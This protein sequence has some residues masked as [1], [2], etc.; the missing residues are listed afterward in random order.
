MHFWVFFLKKD[1][2]Q[3][4]TRK[5]H[6]FNKIFSDKWPSF[7][8]W[9]HPASKN[10]FWKGSESKLNLFRT[11]LNLRTSLLSKHLFLCKSHGMNFF[12][13]CTRTN[14]YPV[15]VFSLW[16]HKLLTRILSFIEW[17]VVIT[18]RYKGLPSRKPTAS[19]PK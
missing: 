7:M 6:Y 3:T 15:S 14:Q 12:W 8:Y 13:N 17:H 4:T 16:C 1:V 11:T 18:K 2:I 10:I 5:R 19:P 9:N